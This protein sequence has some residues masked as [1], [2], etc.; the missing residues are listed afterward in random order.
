MLGNGTLHYSL[1]SKA[2]AENY[3][4]FLRHAYE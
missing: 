3:M 1:Y 4:D 2:N